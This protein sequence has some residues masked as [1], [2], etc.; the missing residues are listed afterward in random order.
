MLGKRQAIENLIH[1]LLLSLVLTCFTRASQALAPAAVVSAAVAPAAVTATSAPEL[2]IAT[3]T[4]S[5]Q[6]DNPVDLDKLA[7]MLDKSGPEG[8]ADRLRAVQ[9]LLGMAKR[10]AHSLLQERLR[11]SEDPDRLRQTILESLGVHML[12]SPSAQFGGADAT[13]RKVILTGY[14][15]ACVPFWRDAQASR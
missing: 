12:G 11:R 4:S 13:L 1:A 9:Q 3:A 10:E 8:K 14:L 7:A 2:R 15:D 5:D 6:Q